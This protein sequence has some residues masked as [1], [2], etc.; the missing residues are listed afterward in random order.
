[1]SLLR[2][3]RPQ[4]FL[5]LSQLIVLEATLLMFQLHHVHSPA[6]V[7]TPVASQDRDQTQDQGQDARLVAAL[8]VKSNKA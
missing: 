2:L 7:N 4:R 1:M 5:I 3:K 6:L 8:V